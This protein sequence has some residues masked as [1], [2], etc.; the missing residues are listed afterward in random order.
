MQPRSRPRSCWLARAYFLALPT[1]HDSA[2][3]N[4]LVRWLVHA[5]ACAL[6]SAVHAAL[7]VRV[8]MS[9]RRL[10]TCARRASQLH[11]PGMN[12]S[13]CDQ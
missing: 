10:R 9:C 7:C 3:R 13:C 12:R 5:R 11:M 4:L 1:A 8:L 6:H 2:Q